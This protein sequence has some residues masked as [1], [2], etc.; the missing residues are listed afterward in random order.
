MYKIK[1]SKNV[2]KSCQ[3]G[4]TTA[5]KELYEEYHRA[6][7][8]LAYRFARNIPDAEALTQDIFLKVSEKI[9]SFRFESRF[10]TFSTW[11]YTVAVNECLK[12]IEQK[13]AQIDGELSRS[14]IC[15]VQ[16][17]LQKCRERRQTSAHFGALD[18]LAKAD[19]VPDPSV[20]PW[21]KTRRRFVDEEA[22]SEGTRMFHIFNKP[23]EKLAGT[24]CFAAYVD[25][26]ISTVTGRKSV[27]I[28]FNARIDLGA[29]ITCVPK[30][31][32]EKLTPLLLGKPVLVRGHDGGVKRVWTY[33]AIISIHG[34]PAEDQ[35]KSYRPERGVL[36]TDSDIGLI[37]MDI[38]SKWSLMFDGVLK[39]FSAEC[40]DQSQ[41]ISS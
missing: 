9:G 3:Q 36:L 37:G 28:S 8:R 17:Y 20:D 30:T 39:A 14:K 23:L 15:Q 19:V 1:I 5:L 41:D 24:A 16:E 18:R 22:N 26:T 31:Q 11:F 21:R 32:V 10:S 6:I 33:R 12:H 40:I 4:N 35:L 27:D 7:Y 29:D 25:A 34:H 13:S 38:V 2:V